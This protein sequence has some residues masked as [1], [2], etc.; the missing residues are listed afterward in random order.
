[1]QF[2]RSYITYKNDVRLHVQEFKTHTGTYYL[3]HKANWRY[4]NLS[5]KPFTIYRDPS[6]SVIVAY[7]ANYEKTIEGALIIYPD[8]TKRFIKNMTV[9]EAVQ[10]FIFKS[11]N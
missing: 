1:M 3:T 8:K 6:T 4:V 5:V 2:I 11:N 7:V 10:Q 9:N